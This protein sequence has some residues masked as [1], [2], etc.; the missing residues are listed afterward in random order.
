MGRNKGHNGNMNLIDLSLRNKKNFSR[1]FPM[2][3]E[4]NGDNFILRQ[5]PEG[6]R[7]A[8]KTF[9]PFPSAKIVPSGLVKHL[10]RSCRARNG[11]SSEEA[12]FFL[13]LAE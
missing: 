7:F 3:L 8:G 9:G 10:A 5:S 12:L 6:N 13:N 11:L 2:I 4:M 1:K